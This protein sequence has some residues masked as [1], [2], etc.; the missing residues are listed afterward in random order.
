MPDIFHD[1]SINAPAERVFSAITTPEDLDQWW[2]KMAAGKCELG[3]AYQLWFGPEFD[4]RGKVTR[5]APNQEFEWEIT[6]A[7]EDWTGTKVGF[8]LEEQA[9]STKVSFYHTGWP[10]EN[11][12]FRRSNYCWAM[13]LRVLKRYVELGERVPYDERTSA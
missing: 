4:W 12:H 10:E 5:C 13:Y 3:Q 8:R 7:D 9:G 2:T 11:H 6:R 1:F